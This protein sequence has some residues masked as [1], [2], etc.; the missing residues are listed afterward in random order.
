MIPKYTILRTDDNFYVQYDLPV[1]SN[2]YN[3]VEIEYALQINAIS[4]QLNT[5]KFNIKWIYDG[6][7]ITQDNDANALIDIAYTQLDAPVLT[8]TL[9]G[10]S[11]EVELGIL[12]RIELG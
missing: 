5:G 3:G 4:A 12:E 7:E 1:D 2:N 9:F 10:K 11:I 6:P 8:N